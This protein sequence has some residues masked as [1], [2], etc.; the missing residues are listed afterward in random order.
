MPKLYIKWAPGDAVYTDQVKQD[1][2]VQ[3][4]DTSAEAYLQNIK[5]LAKRSRPKAKFKFIGKKVPT[6]PLKVDRAKEKPLTKAKIA[7]NEE[8]EHAVKRIEIWRYES[9]LSRRN[10][11]EHLEVTAIA[12][13]AYMKG[14]K[15]VMGNIPDE[16]WD[17]KILEAM[18]EAKKSIQDWQEYEFN[19]Y[20]KLKNG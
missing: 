19:N 16:L 1:Q 10:G 20:T 13:A 6:S 3:F 8:R 2:A 11:W 9:R 17:K 18:D 4:A 12:A 5:E 14:I 15:A 7:K